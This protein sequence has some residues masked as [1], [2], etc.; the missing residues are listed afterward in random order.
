M[1]AEFKRGQVWY[2][3]LSPVVGS[4]QGGLR[5]VLIVSNDM[6]NRYSPTVTICPITSQVKNPLPT[7]TTLLPFTKRKI[8]GTVLC[9]QVRT[10][11]KS[12]LFDYMGEATAEEMTRVSK[13]LKIQLNLF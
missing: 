9:E 8:K 10:I 6:N 12:R 2:A 11:D 1:S 4:E 7:H 3:D 5:P 13:A